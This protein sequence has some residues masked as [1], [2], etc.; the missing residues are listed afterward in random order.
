LVRLAFPTPFSER[1]NVP[2]SVDSP[3][4]ITADVFSISGRR[5]RRITDEVV[6][7]GEH[8]LNWDGRFDDGRLAPSGIY[9]L[10]VVMGSDAVTR[11]LV[12]AR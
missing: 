8:L 11:K 4:L 1:V 12:L 7:V 2:V 6:E 3:T 10:R 9:F 5:V